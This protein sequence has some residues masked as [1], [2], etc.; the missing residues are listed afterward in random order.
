MRLRAVLA[1][2]RLRTKYDIIQS[3][4]M[5]ITAES[6]IRKREAWITGKNNM[7]YQFG[8]YGG[9]HCAFGGVL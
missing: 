2:L 4:Y 8:I 7:Q 6:E 3:G 5:R 9:I 1:D